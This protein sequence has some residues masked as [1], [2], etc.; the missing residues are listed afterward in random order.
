VNSRIIATRF[1]GAPLNLAVVQAYAPT[2]DSTDEEIEKI[3]EDLEKVLNELPNKD[4]KVIERHVLVSASASTD[5]WRHIN[6]FYYYYYYCR[7][8]ECQSWYGQ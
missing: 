3:Y 2:T 7:S 6:I 1:G 8:P 5:M 4:I